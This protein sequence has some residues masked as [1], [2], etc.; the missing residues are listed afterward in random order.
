M[1]ARLGAEHHV[2][3]NRQPLAEPDALHGAG[4]TELGEIVG[5]MPEKGNTVV[6]DRPTTRADKAA[7]GVEKSRLP[8]AV[9]PDQADDL[10]VADLH[11]DAVQGAQS[12][13]STERSETERHPDAASASAGLGAARRSIAGRFFAAAGQ[14][15]SLRSLRGEHL[16]EGGLLELADGRLRDLV[17]ELEAVRQP[18]LGE[19]RCEELTQFLGRRRTARLQARRR[20]AAAPATRDRGWRSPPPRRPPGVPS[21]RSRARPRR[22][23]RRLT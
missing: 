22:S 17:D 11:R 10:A 18:P 4:D 21:A 7:D 3:E 15:P 14:A 16:S 1:K 2:L 13:N 12:P 20:R 9:R 5:T 8:G 6:G 23:T 19:L